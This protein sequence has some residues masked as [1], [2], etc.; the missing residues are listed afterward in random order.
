MGE[1]LEEELCEVHRTALHDLVR[2]LLKTD[3]FHVNIEP[4]SKKGK[5]F[6]EYLKKDFNIY[7]LKFRRQFSWN[8]VSHTLQ[9]SIRKE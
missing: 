3:N 6:C 4:G 5:Q 9:R 2:D 8:C 1:N 7:S